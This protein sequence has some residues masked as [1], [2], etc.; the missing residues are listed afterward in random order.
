VKFHYEIRR[1]K[2]GS[3]NSGTACGERRVREGQVGVDPALS[4]LDGKIVGDERT[5]CEE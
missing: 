2:K 4:I 5:G 3:T 1:K